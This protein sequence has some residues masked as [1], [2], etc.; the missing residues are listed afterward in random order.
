MK[1]RRRPATVVGRPAFW[2][3]CDFPGNSVV[4]PRLADDVRVQAA[5][6]QLERVRKRIFGA[7]YFSITAGG[8]AA[9]ADRRML[10][11]SSTVRLVSIRSSMGRTTTSPT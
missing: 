7:L 3:G 6:D 9:P 1:G 4:F 2:N 8:I 5:E 11:P 10:I